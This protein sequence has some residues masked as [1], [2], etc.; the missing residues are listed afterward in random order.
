MIKSIRAW[1]ALKLFRMAIK[2]DWGVVKEQSAIVN[3]EH[4]EG[5][6]RAEAALGDFLLPAKGKRG[7][8]LGSKNKAKRNAS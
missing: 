3:A 4:R 1:L 6:K 7:R 5:L 8:P 2:L